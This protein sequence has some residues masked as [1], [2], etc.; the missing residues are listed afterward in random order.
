VTIMSTTK[1][2]RSNPDISKS[3]LKTTHPFALN[4]NKEALESERQRARRRGAH[5]ARRADVARNLLELEKQFGRKPIA[6]NEIALREQGEVDT[7]GSEL[8]NNDSAM[9]GGTQ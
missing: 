2:A 3:L 4:K 7:G 5:K 8:Q 9:R 1:A 6:E